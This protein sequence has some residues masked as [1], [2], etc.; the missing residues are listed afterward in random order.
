[1]S[2]TKNQAKAETM[3]AR[4]AAHRANAACASCHNVIDPAGFALESFD[5]IGRFRI[6][7]ESFNALDTSG[8]LPDGSKFTTVAELRTALTRNPE[9]FVNAL[10]ERLLAYSLGRGLEYYD[11][12]VVRKIVRD[13]AP[14]GYKLQALI[15]GVVN[16]TPFLM[17]RAAAESSSLA[18]LRASPVRADFERIQSKEKV[19]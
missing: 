18:E 17:R 6:K 9:L 11:M 5:P 14:G 10:T 13:S 16:S 1:L 12:P 15:S 8:V 19:R 3:R 4:M 7:D 2:E